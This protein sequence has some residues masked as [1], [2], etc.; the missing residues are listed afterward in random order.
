[1]SSPWESVLRAGCFGMEVI[2]CMGAL[3]AHV[4]EGVGF[5]RYLGCFCSG[6]WPGAAEQSLVLE[7]RPACVFGCP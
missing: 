3:N 1:M 5:G 2:V 7:N 6:V 4:L